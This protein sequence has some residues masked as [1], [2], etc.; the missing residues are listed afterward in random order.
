MCRA[1]L[2]AF[3]SLAANSNRPF[4]ALIER[5]QKNAGRPA[6]DGRSTDA[7]IA[8][9]RTHR[10]PSNLRR[11]SSPFI[12]ATFLSLAKAADVVI[13]SRARGYMNARGISLEALRVLN[14]GL[15][16]LRISPFGDD[17]PWANFRGSDLIHLALGGV[18]MN[19]GYDPCPNGHHDTPPIAPRCHAAASMLPTSATD[20]PNRC[21]NF[22][23]I[24][25][26][27]LSL[28]LNLKNPEGRKVLEGLIREAD[29]IVEGFS[30]GTMDRMGLGYE[31]LKELNPSI[32]Y[33]H[34][35]AFGQA[36]TYGNARGF[37]P[38]A[39]AI[40]GISELSGLPEPY[41]PA[42]IGYPYLDWFGA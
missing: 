28:S 39:Q 19:C 22:M 37:G 35:S 18:M 17:G 8:T 10:C 25:A 20:N 5:R 9:H 21:G 7:V 1:K 32:I 33:V 16:Y 24:N 6:I 27:K 29:M 38:T 11:H 41:P 12:Q 4:F 13:N 23:E 40:S 3:G 15:I 31:K 30:P 2:P 14:L 42:G 34:Q 26:G 36:G